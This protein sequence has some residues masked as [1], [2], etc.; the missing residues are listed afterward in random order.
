MDFIGMGLLIFLSS[1]EKEWGKVKNVVI[2]VIFWTILNS[3]VFTI[4]HFL[5]N[6]PIINWTNIGS[7]MLFAVLYVIIYIKQQK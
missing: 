5:H 7:Y 6:L 1:R 3:I 2:M 4:L